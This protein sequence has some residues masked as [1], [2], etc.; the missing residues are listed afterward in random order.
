MIWESRYWKNDLLRNAVYLKKKMMCQRWTESTMANFEKTIM[1]GFYI[2]RK[3]LEAK[4]LSGDTI[5]YTFRAITYRCKN[6]NVN[7]LNWHKVIEL[8]NLENGVKEDL[9]LRYVSNKI[10]HSF[11]FIGVFGE[12]NNIEAV[13]FNSDQS[14]N[15]KLYSINVIDIIYL[16]EKAGNDY[17]EHIEYKLNQKTNEYEVNT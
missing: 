14:K 5:A 17:P 12:N 1:I 11:V 2:I 3:L 13:M 15:E 9:D 4:K 16:F 10:I 8:Y 7:I 6:K